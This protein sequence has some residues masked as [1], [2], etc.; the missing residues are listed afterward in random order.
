MAKMAKTINLQRIINLED[1]RRNN[2][3]IEAAYRNIH[4]DVIWASE[5]RRRAEQEAPGYVKLL[6]LDGTAYYLFAENDGTLRVHTSAPTAND[7][8]DAVGDQTD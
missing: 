3:A 8:G 5:V 4:N 6:S 1:V 2:V 7:D